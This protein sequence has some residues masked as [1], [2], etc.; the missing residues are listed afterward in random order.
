MKRI[1]FTLLSSLI[2]F[3]CQGQ[4]LF[5]STLHESDWLSNPEITINS[6]VMAKNLALFK[7]RYTRDSIKNDFTIWTF[8]HDTLKI[9]KHLT[10]QNKDSLIGRFKFDF[11]SD[12]VHLSIYINREKFNFKIGIVSTGSYAIL[13]QRKER[14]VNFVATIHSDQEIKAGLS[15]NGYIVHLSRKMIKE[16]DGKEVRIKGKVTWVDANSRNKR[17]E[18][19]QGFDTITKHLLQPVI[20]IVKN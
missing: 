3:A 7:P 18:V 16:L 14:R 2:S 9:V 20:T 1:Y 15:L 17:G 6:L 12:K 5:Y 10:K 8:Q 11:D 19:Q 13:Y 4:T